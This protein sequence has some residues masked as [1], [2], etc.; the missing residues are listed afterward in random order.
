VV[1]ASPHPDGEDWS[2]PAD[3]TTAQARVGVRVP[4]VALSADGSAV[5]VWARATHRNDGSILHS[6]AEAATRPAGG[7]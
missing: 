1:P 6:A 2:A 7:S 3:L 5:A 4:Q